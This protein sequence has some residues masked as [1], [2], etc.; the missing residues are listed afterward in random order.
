MPLILSLDT[1]ASGCSVAL[2]E[3]GKNLAVSE[4]RKEHSHG[5]RLA[6]LIKQVLENSGVTA[7]ELS[8]VAIASGPGSYTGLRIGTSTAKGLCYAL[9]KPLIAIDS[10]SAMSVLFV[11]RNPE[12]GLLFCPMLDARRMEVYCAVLDRELRFIDPIQA[13]VLDE[14]SFAE[15]LDK[16]RVV[17]FGDG[18]VKSKE[19]IK[20]PNAMFA[21][22]ISSS[23]LGVG[24][25]AWRKYQER[26]FEDLV[27]FEPLYLKEFLIKRSNKMDALL[28]K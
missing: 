22:G 28:N 8:A 20:H 12:D 3:D 27:H 1:S 13:K 10:L 11:E 25:L 4:I 15:L 5:A 2:H 18:S 7:S 26:R 21:D 9:D 24:E 14:S 16:R 23:A 17:F 19:I 6:L